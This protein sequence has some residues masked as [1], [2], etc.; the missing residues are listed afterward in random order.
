MPTSLRT[1]RLLLRSWSVDDAAGYRQ[2]WQE[3]D[4]RSQRTIDASDRPTVAD[5]PARIAAQLDTTATTGFGLMAVERLEQ[6]DFIGYC[7]LVRRPATPDEP[8]LAYELLRAT[9]GYGY[10]TEAARAVCDA[11]ARAGRT[12]LWADVRDWNLGS[13]RVLDK[14]G[15]MAVGSLRGGVIT[16]VRHLV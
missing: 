5:L 6:S 7:G 4:P 8:E 11:A 16:M 13:I 3:R 9:H 2:L 14:L 12:R 15:F 10:A 1:D